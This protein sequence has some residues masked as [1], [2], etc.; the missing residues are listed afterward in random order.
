MV[1]CGFHLGMIDDM[2]DR[3]ALDGAFW[4]E[5]IVQANMGTPGRK[6]QARLFGLQ[7][8]EDITIARVEDDLNRAPSNPAA[9]QPHERLEAMGQLS[10]VEQFAGRERVE[11]T[12]EHVESMLMSFDALE[13]RT[14]FLYAAP[15]GPGRVNG[16]QVHAKDADS[17]PLGHHFQKCMTRQARAMPLSMNDRQTAHEGQG[18][19]R[20]RTADLHAG[21]VSQPFDNGRPGRFLKDDEVRIAGANHR[22][23]RPLAASPPV[24]DVVSEKAKRHSV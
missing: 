13:E 23:E 1:G 16:A 6:G 3:G 7:R 2:T 24:A 21:A 19:T 10:N 5:E 18:F 12:R 11:V 22:K 20:T 4:R 14:Q 9:A 15:F 8:T 17:I